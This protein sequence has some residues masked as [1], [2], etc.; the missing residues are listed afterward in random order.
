MQCNFCNF[1]IYFRKWQKCQ[2]IICE[3]KFSNWFILSFLQN[4]FLQN[5]PKFARINIPKLI[6]PFKVIKIFLSVRKCPSQVK[7]HVCI[8]NRQPHCTKLWYQVEKNKNVK[9]I[10]TDAFWSA[11]Q[12]IEFTNKEKRLKKAK[13]LPLPIVAPSGPTTNI[14]PSTMY[15]NVGLLENASSDPTMSWCEVLYPQIVNNKHPFSCS[16]DDWS[17]KKV[18]FVIFSSKHFWPK[19]YTNTLERL[20]SLWYIFASG[21]FCWFYD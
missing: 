19:P 15:T 5:W 21:I 8:T 11:D 2:W 10:L 1:G 20:I 17:S 13:K 12:W 14:F 3:K 9:S 4:F 16:S 7:T 6:I 18:Y